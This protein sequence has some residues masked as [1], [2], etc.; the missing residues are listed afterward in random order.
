[1]HRSR[2]EWHPCSPLRVPG[3]G[4]EPTR[5]REPAGLSR[6]RLPFR[7][8]GLAGGYAA[9]GDRWPRLLQLEVGI[10]RIP[11][12][13]RDA[14]DWTKDERGLWVRRRSTRRPWVPAISPTRAAA[15]DLPA[16]SSAARSG[17][18]RSAASS[19]PRRVP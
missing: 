13:E 5:S 15:V 16:R 18:T 6:L 10:R 11:L 17:A 4:V 2:R 12:R 3:A 8:P 7:H 19:L 14:R 1:M 9:I